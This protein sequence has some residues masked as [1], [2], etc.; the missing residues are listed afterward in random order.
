[1]IFVRGAK[2]LHTRDIGKYVCMIGKYVCMIFFYCGGGHLGGTDNLWGGGHVP[3]RPPVATPLLKCAN[4]HICAKK[5]RPQM[6]KSILH[7]PLMCKHDAV[8]CA[9]VQF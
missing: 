6:C 1:M 5:R 9:K 2:Y 3:P 4:N 8:K 7:Q